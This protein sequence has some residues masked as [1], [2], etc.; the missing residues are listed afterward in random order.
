MDLVLNAFDD[1]SLEPE[2]FI[3]AGDKVLAPV[4][5]TGRG[6]DSGIPVDV[7]YILVFTLRAGK[8]IRVDSYYDRRRALEAAG[9]A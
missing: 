7:R 4:H 5:Q 2:E 8:G 9:V 6:K 3:D 1:Y